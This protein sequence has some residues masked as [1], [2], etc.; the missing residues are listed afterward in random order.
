MPTA[1]APLPIAPDDLAVL[2]RWA[3]ASQLPAVLVQ[4]AK[5][6]LLAAEAWPTPRS[7]TGSGSPARP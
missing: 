2:R 6:L 5:I 4:R 1:A 3:R 7:P